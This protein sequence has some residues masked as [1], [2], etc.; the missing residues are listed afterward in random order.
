MDFELIKKFANDIA[1]EYVTNRTPIENHILNFCQENKLNPEQ[2]RNLV[3]LINTLI[4]LFLFENKTDD[5][6]IEF[7][8]LDPDAIL[9]K[10][11]QEL[12]PAVEDNDSET[13]SVDL[14]DDLSPLLKS[15]RNRLGGNTTQKTIDLS[16]IFGPGFMT[17]KEENTPTTKQRQVLLMKIQ[18]TA[19]ELK[20]QYLTAGAQYCEFLDYMATKF[21][22]LYGPDID[23]FAKE[24]YAHRGARALSILQDIYHCLKK[25]FPK[26]EK[27]AAVID[28]T[29][30]E[31]RILD[32]MIQLEDTYR[33]TKLAWEKLNEA[34]NNI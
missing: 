23:E 20:M 13:I 33:T 30:E 3:Q 4:H 31:M 25:P 15:I 1:R 21:A 19:E 26:F 11:F 9:R 2:I 24:A 16:D 28:S 5:K 29:K 34:L 6:I 12:P 7:D 18:K 8:P 14:F 32:S 10:I 17:V 22:A 27:T